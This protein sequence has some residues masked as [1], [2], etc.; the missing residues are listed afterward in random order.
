MKKVV[1]L[2]IQNYLEP[3]HL[4][5]KTTDRDVFT[6][7]FVDKEYDFFPS[8]LDPRII[9]D[10]GANVG[11]SSLFFAHL[12]PKA[13]IFAIEPE[14]SNF[15]MLVE[16]TKNYE[17]IFSIHAALWNRNCDL[18]INNRG[19]GEWGF[20]MSE[21][22]DVKNDRIPGLT[23]MDIIDK[24]A[25]SDHIDILKLD[26]EGSEKELFESNYEGWI[27]KVDNIII[28]LHDRFK[29]GCSEAFFKVVKSNNFHIVKRN[30]DTIF[31]ER[32]K[33]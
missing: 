10:G 15:R 3:I 1:S 17:R 25:K 12:Y 7:I 32:L 6:Q 31:L 30:G 24:Y 19:V 2:R 5:Q 29:R 22:E 14:K 33:C 4:R 20:R 28:E 8:K 11:F 13:N 9:I 18:Y 21:E 26:V 16:N 27:N 23:I